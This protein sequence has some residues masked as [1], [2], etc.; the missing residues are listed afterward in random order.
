MTELPPLSEAPMVSVIV[1]SYNQGAYIREALDSILSQTYRPL[2]VIVVDGASTDET[3]DVLNAYNDI[4]EIKWV[5]EPDSGVVEAVNKGFQRA[6][7]EIGAIQSAD[8]V[9][10]PGAVNAGVG[11]LKKNSALGFVF[12]DVQK[13]DETGR[14]LDTTAISA[15]SLEGFLAKTLWIPQQT[16]FFR[17]AAA[18]AL[19]GWRE[20]VPYAADTDLWLRLA[21]RYP[22]EKID[23]VLA[24]RRMH[25]HQRDKQAAR[26][27]S[28]YSRMIRESP[29]IAAAPAKLRRAAAAGRL[30]HMNRYGAADSYVKR[31]IRLWAASLLYPAYFRRYPPA[32]YI[33]FW[34]P[35]RGALSRL[36]KRQSDG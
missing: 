33:P 25:A 4:P 19:G 23:A 31:W 9:Y 24:M 22:A 17:L 28:D 29:D 16:T 2:E 10:Y 3:L 12:G 6:Q 14:V 27:A 35:I 21:F 26:I 15:Y 18:K 32:A 13:T 20:A 11:A 36:R 7:G 8:D 1:P 5:S 34:F 30:V